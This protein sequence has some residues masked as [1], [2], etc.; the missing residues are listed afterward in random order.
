MTCTLNA[1]QKKN[2]F[3]YWMSNKGSSHVKNACLVFD[4]AFRTKQVISFVP[5]VTCFCELIIIPSIFLWHDELYF[6]EVISCWNLPRAL[7][8]SLEARPRLFKSF[9]D[10][11]IPSPYEVS[12]GHRTHLS[13]LKIMAL[14]I[15]LLYFQGAAYSGLEEGIQPRILMPPWSNW[16]FHLHAAS[17]RDWGAH[18]MYIRHY[19]TGG[20]P[21]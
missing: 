2:K 14:F 11:R 1:Y 20:I 6:I 17:S 15:S 5:T 3:L 9:H 10:I 7:S 8:F 4:V 16:R 21:F 12:W 19:H 13:K 18:T